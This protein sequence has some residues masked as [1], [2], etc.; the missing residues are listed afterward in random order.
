MLS[1]GWEAKLLEKTVISEQWS[2]VS[3][4]FSAAADETECTRHAGG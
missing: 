2:V 1:V 4:G 3:H